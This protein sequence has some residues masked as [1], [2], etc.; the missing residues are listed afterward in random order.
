MYDDDDGG[1]GFVL[2]VVSDAPAASAKERKRGKR[3]GTSPHR[4]T[5]TCHNNETCSHGGPIRRRKGRYILR[6]DQTGVLSAPL[7]FLAQ[8]DP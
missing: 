5:R 1:G 6:T 4:Q 8:E 3:G 7:P 2:N